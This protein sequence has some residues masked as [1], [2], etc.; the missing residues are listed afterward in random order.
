MSSFS[1]STRLLDEV[2]CNNPPDNFQGWIVHVLDLVLVDGPLPDFDDKD[3]LRL[4][5]TTTHESR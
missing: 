5:V 1:D 4:R 3:E 2:D